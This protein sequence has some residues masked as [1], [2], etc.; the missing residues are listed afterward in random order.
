MS[1]NLSDA[2]LLL[3]RIRSDQGVIDTMEDSSAEYR[4]ILRLKMLSF[5]RGTSR[6]CTNEISSCMIMKNTESVQ[7]FGYAN[8]CERHIEGS[9]GR[10]GAP[11]ISKAAHHAAAQLNCRV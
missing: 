2:T 1:R 5:L 4:K 6:Y 10:A 7:I 9:W 3:V 11:S 8:P